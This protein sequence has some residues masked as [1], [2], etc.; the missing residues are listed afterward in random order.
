MFIPSAILGFIIGL[1]FWVVCLLILRTFGVFKKAVIRVFK[2]EKVDDMD[3]AVKYVISGDPWIKISDAEK[4]H[5]VNGSIKKSVLGPY[6]PE[7]MAEFNQEVLQTVNYL[8]TPDK[9]VEGMRESEDSFAG[10]GRQSWRVK[11]RLRRSSN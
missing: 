1:L 9:G 11:G 7:K 3:L 6:S 2:K 5:S 8:N 10:Q 4:I